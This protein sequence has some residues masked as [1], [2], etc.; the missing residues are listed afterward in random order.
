MQ[1]KCWLIDLNDD[2]DTE[3]FPL[4]FC[5]VKNGLVFIVSVEQKAGSVDVNP[6]WL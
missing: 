5:Y 2:V 4:S 1:S 3:Q 6:E